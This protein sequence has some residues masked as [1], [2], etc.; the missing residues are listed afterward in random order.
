[1]AIRY[2]AIVASTHNSRP[3]AVKFTRLLCTPNAAIANTTTARISSTRRRVIIL[4]LDNGR[5]L[6]DVAELLQRLLVLVILADL[7]R[8]A[9]HAAQSVG[10]GVG[11]AHRARCLRGPAAG[12][13]T[14]QVRSR[15]HG[16]IGHRNL[17]GISLIGGPLGGIQDVVR[18]IL[19]AAHPEIG[20]IVGGVE[21]HA[22]ERVEAI[23]PGVLLPLEAVE[24]CPEFA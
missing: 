4:A 13:Q 3:S 18:D 11:A 7:A 1:M 24:G 23:E 8:G 20:D 21:A 6:Q 14:G 17:S 22:G 16:V 12:D 2:P 15:G 5:V 19:A 9:S 10:P